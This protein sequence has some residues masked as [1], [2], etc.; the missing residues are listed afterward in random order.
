MTSADPGH[1]L[2]T[3]PLSSYD[4]PE[5]VHQ[6]IAEAGF[7]FATP[8][9]AKAL[10]IT[11]AGRDIAGQAQ[12]GTG[13]TAAF[14][15]TAFTRLLR[16]RRPR[17]GRGPRCLVVA[18]TRELV[19]QIRDDA[20]KLARHTGLKTLAVFGGMAYLRPP[21]D[22]ALLGDPLR[23]GHGTRLRAHEQRPEGRGRARTGRRV[24]HHR[25]AVPR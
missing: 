9:Q 1:H 12:T 4:L 19:V 3:V 20:E 8:I 15:V 10:P 23:P 22:D 11:L 18:P 6:G 5:K 25:G 14:L 13:K 16:N 21:P 17:P 24:R 2:S 7:V